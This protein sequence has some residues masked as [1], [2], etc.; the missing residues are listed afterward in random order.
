MGQVTHF[1]GIGFTWKNDMDGNL[2]VSITQQS[3]AE[4]LIDSLAFASAISTFATPYH[5]GLS[6]DSVPH[7]SMS[8]ND[9]D[10]L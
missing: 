9:R 2:R 3:F 1:L 8:S 5:L 6:I 7:Q 10:I 4:T